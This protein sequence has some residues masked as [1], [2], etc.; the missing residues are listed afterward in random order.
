IPVFATGQSWWGA[1]GDL[2]WP[3]LALVLAGGTLMVDRLNK[4][5][6]V[7][8]FLGVYFGL[9]TA[10]SFGDAAAVA[11]LFRAPFVQAAVFRAVFMLTDPPTSPSRTF[12]QVWVGALV[13]VVACASQ[14]LG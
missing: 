9:C 6:L 8:T 12:D 7:L 3:F 14:L 5:P 10:L 2:A 1:G 4:F 13:A 11:E